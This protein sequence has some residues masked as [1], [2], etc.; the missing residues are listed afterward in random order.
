MLSID[1]YSKKS[2]A[3]VSCSYA[4]L[5]SRYTTTSYFSFWHDVSVQSAL[6]F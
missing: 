1:A 4:N 2:K 3:K 5:L 6:D